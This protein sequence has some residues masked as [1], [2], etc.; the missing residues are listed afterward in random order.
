MTMTNTTTK[1]ALRF[2]TEQAANAWLAA[3]VNYGRAHRAGVDFIALQFADGAVW[4]FT[5]ADEMVLLPNW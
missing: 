3:T 4:A 5:Q 1:P 2:A